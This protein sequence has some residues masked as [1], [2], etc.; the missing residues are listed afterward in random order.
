MVI[1]SDKK[2]VITGAASGIGKALAIK[3][4]N[5]GSHLI[6]ADIDKVKL[7]QTQAEIESIGLSL[8]HI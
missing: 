6:L 1:F 5:E 3:F 8:I 4:A 7:K 2:V